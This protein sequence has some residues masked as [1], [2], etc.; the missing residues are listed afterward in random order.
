MQV[1]R[2]SNS[3]E[4]LDYFTDGLFFLY[5]STGV[6]IYEGLISIIYPQIR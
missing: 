6:F 4:M 3:N 2:W 1:F 5:A